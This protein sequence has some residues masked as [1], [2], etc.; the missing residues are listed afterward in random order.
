[1]QD[2]IKWDQND[3]KLL[4]LMTGNENYNKE[5]QLSKNDLNKN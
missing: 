3:C 5:R 1:M 2:T 4:I